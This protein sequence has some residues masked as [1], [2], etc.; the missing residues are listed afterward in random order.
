MC[1]VL[2]GEH[3]QIFVEFNVFYNSVLSGGSV[4]SLAADN[5]AIPLRVL[6]A[7]LACYL[8]Y[9]TPPAGT[10][11]FFGHMDCIEL[12]ARAGAELSLVDAV[13][14]RLLHP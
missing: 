14:L 8:Q 9:G 2:F 3:W 4:P 12:L 6:R 10:A 7:R 11:M 1:L 5:P 13:S